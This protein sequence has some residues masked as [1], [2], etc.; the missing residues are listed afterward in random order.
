M[1]IQPHGLGIGAHRLAGFYIGPAVAGNLPGS[2]DKYQR[3]NSSCKI[4]PGGHIAGITIPV[5]GFFN[6]TVIN[7]INCLIAIILE[8]VGVKIC[9]NIVTVVYKVGDLPLTIGHGFYYQVFLYLLYCFFATGHPCKQQAKNQEMF[10]CF[11]QHKI[12]NLYR[13]SNSI[14]TLFLYLKICLKS[15]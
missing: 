2:V 15:S 4:G 13:L 8:P 7:G 5:P 9:S 3:M 12:S 6:R 10:Y 14:R 11:H 1:L